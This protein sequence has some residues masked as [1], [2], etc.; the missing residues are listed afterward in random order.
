MNHKPEPT[1]Y[2][3]YYSKYINLVDDDVQ[4]ALAMQ[5]EST[6]AFVNRIPLDKADYAYAEDKWT[7]KEVIGH[8]IDLERI[9]AYRALRFSRNDPKDLSGF[10]ENYYVAN[11]RFKERTLG[12]LAREFKSLREANLYLFKNLNGKELLRRGTANIAMVSVRALL[13]IIAGHE[14]HHIQIL[15][16]RYLNAKDA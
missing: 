2:S 4:T 13:F 12:D 6:F 8:M 1:E 5:M 16:E 11:S 14:L 10:N 15:K 7:V 3:S 9:M